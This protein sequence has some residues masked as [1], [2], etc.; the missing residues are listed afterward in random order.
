[1]SAG[2]TTGRGRGWWGLAALLALALLGCPDEDD[3]VAGDDDTTD[4]DDA[5]DDDTTP[6]VPCVDAVAGAPLQGTLCANDAACWFGDIGQ[7]QYQGFALASGGDFDGDGL[8]DLLVGAPGYDLTQDDGRVAIYTAASFEA[9]L[10]AP[11]A[12]LTGEQPLENAGYAVAFAGDVDG[13][14]FDDVLAGARNDSDGGE[15]AGAVYLLHG[16]ALNNDPEA[17]ETLPADTA[18]RGAH[19]F[20]RVG[21]GLSGLGD[22]TGDGTAEL[23]VAWELFNESQGFEFADDGHVALFHGAAGGLAAEL[24]PYDADVTLEAPLTVSQLGYAMDH[25]DVTGDGV[26]ELLVGA[27]QAETSRG[28]LYLFRG[29]DLATPGTYVAEELAACYHV[30][31]EVG[32]ELG[33]AVAFLGD[34]DGDGLADIGV[35]SPQSSRTWPDGGAVTVLRGAAAIDDGTPPEVLV[36]IGSEWDDFAFGGD[37]ARHGDSDGDGLAE[38][39]VGGRFAYVGPVMKGGRAYLFHGRAAGWDGLVDATDADAGVSGIGVADNLGTGLAL[40]D[41]DGDG[42]D[43]LLVGAPYRDATGNDSGEIYLFWGPSR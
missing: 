23:A 30:G 25:G 36:V 4:D 35:G 3:D 15:G 5:G 7:A 33:T 31:E 11:V 24:D 41:L 27:P 39:W 29:A 13:D 38:L 43:E 12:Q 14:G 20:G 37:I 6:T 21:V 2:R 1:M 32:E 10:P 16:R 26:E 17:P 8:E 18:I 28:R 40:A 42:A 19:E 22:V 34:V 9:V